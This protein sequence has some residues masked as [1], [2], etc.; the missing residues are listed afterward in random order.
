MFVENRF[1]FGLILMLCIVCL[2]TVG[3]AA[4]EDDLAQLLRTETETV[5]NKKITSYPELGVKIQFPSNVE[6]IDFEEGMPNP[7]G[8][9]LAVVVEPFETLQADGD[10]GPDISREDAMQEQAALENGVYG[11]ESLDDG[12]EDTRTVVP[13]SGGINAKT[14]IVLGRF[15]VCDI[16]FEHV[17]T[18]YWNDCRFTLFFFAPK[19][20]LMGDN[21]ELFTKDK[22]NCGD[23]LMWDITNDS[24]KVF[25]EKLRSGKAGQKAAA[26][27]TMFDG[28]LQ[29][30]VF[31]Q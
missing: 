7:E 31:E 6:W 20:I 25:L 30:I 11:D 15:E 23:E 2:P 17:A 1:I 28:I 26:W 9:S 18:F 3:S 4:S 19:K 29:G 8:Y 24:S 16:T 22:D 14:N 27:N 12:M 10:G 13:L 21:K 5:G